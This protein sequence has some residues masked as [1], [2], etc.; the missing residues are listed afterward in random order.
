MSR[1]VLALLAPCIN[2]K[3]PRRLS[4]AKMADWIGLNPIVYRIVYVTFSYFL[5]NLDGFG[6]L[7]FLF[8]YYFGVDLSCSYVLVGEHF[9]DCVDV[10]SVA[11]EQ[12]GVGVTE[13]VEGYVLVY[14]CAFEPFFEVGVNLSSG[15]S[16][17]NEAGSGGSA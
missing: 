12:S 8:I 13:A 5:L 15:E 14:T 6:C 1:V 4:W 10:G 16:F 3:S 17:E 2:K 11:Q 7:A 9:A